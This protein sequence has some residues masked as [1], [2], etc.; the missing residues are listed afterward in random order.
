MAMKAMMGKKINP[1]LLTTLM[2]CKEEHA[3]CV[4]PNNARHEECGLGDDNAW[5]N[6]Y[7]DLLPCCTYEKTKE[8]TLPVTGP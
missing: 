5:T 2:Q 8:T 7:R 3:R 6:S 4:Q 1:L